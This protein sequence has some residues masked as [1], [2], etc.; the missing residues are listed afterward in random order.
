MIPAKV[1]GQREVWQALA[2][3]MPVTT[4]LRNLATMTR[5]GV[6][7]PMES[8]RACEV[9]GSIGTD[10]GKVHPVGVL[11]ALL[12]YRSGKGVRGQHTWDPVPQVVEALD[13]A[14]ERSFARAPQTNRR[15]YRGIDVSGSMNRGIVS[16][17]PGLRPGWPPRPW[18]CRWPEGSPTTTLRP[19]PALLGATPGVSARPRWCRWTSGPVTASPRQYA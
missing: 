13:A 18:Q 7:S 16:G 15:F 2:E 9:L 19:S 12:T 5:L 6:T 14:F 17:V 4:C 11:S 3:G 10:R 1:M 8:A